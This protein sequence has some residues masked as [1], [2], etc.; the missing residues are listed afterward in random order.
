MYV[1]SC[2]VSSV[3]ISAS[4]FTNIQVLVPY[5]LLPSVLS[6]HL[7]MCICTLYP[8]SL[9]TKLSLLGWGLSKSLDIHFGTGCLILSSSCPDILELG[10]EHWGIRIISGCAL[11]QICVQI[12]A[13]LPPS[14]VTITLNPSSLICKLRSIEIAASLGYWECKLREGM[15][16]V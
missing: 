13:L 1:L 16:S 5:P 2:P 14:C 9:S 7:R 10:E 11:K 8:Q 4:L 15:E 6:Q 12:P 3:S